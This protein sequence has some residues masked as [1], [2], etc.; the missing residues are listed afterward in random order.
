MGKKKSKGKFLFNLLIFLVCCIY[1]KPHTLDSS[2][3]SDECGGDDH[4][5]HRNKNRYDRLPKH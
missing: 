5:D 4:S 1:N 3:S 2:S